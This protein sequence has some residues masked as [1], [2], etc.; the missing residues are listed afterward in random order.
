M[1]NPESIVD[2]FDRRLIPNAAEKNKAV[3]YMSA[4]EDFYNN[5]GFS[6]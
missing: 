2:P 4:L 1:K 5:A 6:A 3:G